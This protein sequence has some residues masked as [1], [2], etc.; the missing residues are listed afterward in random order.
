MPP[1]GHMWKIRSGPD[2]NLGTTW[3][4]PARAIPR[5]DKRKTEIFPVSCVFVSFRALY[6][7]ISCLKFS[8]PAAATTDRGGGGGGGGGGGARRGVLIFR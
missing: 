4:I 7:M 1:C 2:R 5:I 3:A 6:I 8:V